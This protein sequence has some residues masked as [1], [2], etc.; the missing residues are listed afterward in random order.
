LIFKHLTTRKQDP[1][2]MWNIATDLAINST[3]PLDE[4]PEGGLIP[5]QD[6]CLKGKG[7]SPLPEDVK[8]KAG[9]LSK[10]I[11]ELPKNKASEWYMN[12]LRENKDIQ[13]AI[14]ELFKPGKSTSGEGEESGTSAG[15]DHHF[16]HELSEC[17]KE[18]IDA[19]VKKIVKE[20][21]E[22]A[23][24]TNSWGSTPS[25]MKEKI[26]SMLEKSIDWRHVLR[27]FC[28]T[29]QR[30]N[31][32]RSFKKI[33]RKYPYIHPGRKIKHTS[34]LAIYID[35]SGSVVNEDLV[36]FFG[37]LSELSKKV[38]FTVYHF[39]TEVDEDSKYVWRKNKGHVT[40][41]RTRSG[42]TCF[43]AAEDHFRK[44]SGEYDG[45]IVM[46]DGCAPKPKNCI[47]KR[48]WV[49]LPGQKLYFNPEKR[50]TV[51]LMEK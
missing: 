17:E 30:S 26:R 18:L 9:Q 19:K 31:K 28:G 12:K 50:D 49:I 6:T 8:K 11:K 44:V 42:G 43:D 38:T 4:L 27:Y 48:C 15:F 29:K 41:H 25:S 45:Y 22:R 47:S 21:T 35:Q 24:R 2:L 20:A 40:P 10:F 16:D 32:T 36:M 5:G 7:G 23:D 37:A 34:N 51:V 14:N 13:E 39:D 1:H 33:N 3:I 46:T